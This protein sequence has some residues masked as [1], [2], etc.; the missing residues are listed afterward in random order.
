LFNLLWMLFRHFSTIKIDIQLIKMCI[1]EAAR[2]LNLASTSFVTPRLAQY[3]CSLQVAL[4]LIT[5]VFKGAGDL[6]LNL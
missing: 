4:Q 6:S 1:L 2:L 3:T 5:W